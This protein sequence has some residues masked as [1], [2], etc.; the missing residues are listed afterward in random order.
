M[1]SISGKDSLFIL[2]H[3]LILLVFVEFGHAQW[4]NELDENTQVSLFT[5]QPTLVSDG[6]NGVIVFSQSRDVNS[7]LRAQR[8][9]V[10]GN[11]RWPGVQGVRVSSA[12]DAQW[13][14][15]PFG[16]ERFVLPDG[17][18]GSYV[19]YQVGKIIGHMEEPPEPIFSSS[20]FL[21]RVDNSGNRL[22]GLDGLR[23]MPIL[24][25][26][27]EFYQSNINMIPDGT[28]GVYLLWEMSIADSLE[29]SGVYLARIKA[30]GELYWGLTKLTGKSYEYIPYL[31]NNLNLNLYEY[32]GETLP[33]GQRPDRFLKIAKNTGEI[34][35]EHEIEIGT[36]EFGFNSFYDYVES[37][38]GSAIFSF[39]DFRD[40]TLRVQKL[41]GDGNKLWG[42]Y[43]VV[44]A[45]NLKGTT[46][47]EIDS[48]K[49]GGA[50][51][52][53]HTVD[54][55]LV[56]LHLGGVGNVGWRKEFNLKRGEGLPQLQPQRTFNRPMAIAPD[57]NNI[58]ILTDGFQVVTKIGPR[59]DLLYDTLWQTR[60]S[61]RT[62]IAANIFDYAA[63]ADADG[64]CT[65]VWEEVGQFV[66]IR[67][68]RVD[69]HGNLGG[70]TPVEE[71]KRAI[72]TDFILENP[73]PN[74][75][76]DSINIGFSVPRTS[77]VSVK[78]Y[79]I[80][81]REVIALYRQK[82][83]T[84]RQVIQWH[85]KNHR[86]ER[87]PSGVYIVVLRSSTVSVPR[88]VLLLK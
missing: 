34:I 32:P 41:D 46:L 11:L 5:G 23:L 21:Q 49:L 60:I 13:I 47:F 59:D 74:P 43:P 56:L 15:D 37:D 27:A 72:P 8:I 71:Q 16:E 19:A 57:G 10:K 76:T 62:D 63:F 87:L 77:E 48:D 75:F 7:L 81:G 31:D 50:Y 52:W 28:Q 68:Q 35:S 82:V 4:S 88:K 86:G 78:I 1:S 3:S 55:T 65:V 20:V 69:R 33:P 67:A 85:G 45:H 36:G 17:E 80:L 22:F 26:T 44:I 53:Y 54:T 25:D 38:D 83:F 42:E 2:S 18:G 61:N 51:L 58:F 12:V 73:R 14:R 9:D 24:P 66:G 64:G 39:H 84:G 6:E 29:S 79:N 40:D 30:N 70:T